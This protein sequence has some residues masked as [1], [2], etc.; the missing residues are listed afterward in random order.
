MKFMSPPI[1]VGN[2][3]VNKPW[4]ISRPF[5]SGTRWCSP[6]S[7]ENLANK[8]MSSSVK[9]RDHLIVSPI[10]IGNLVALQFSADDCR[11]CEA[12]GTDRGQ[13]LLIRSAHPDNVR[14]D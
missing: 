12:T 4:A 1:L 10:C 3:A 6:S 2:V 14:Q 13:H 9:V 7:P 5:S 11:S 8:R